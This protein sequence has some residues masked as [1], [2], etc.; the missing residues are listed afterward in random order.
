TAGSIYD[1]ACAAGSSVSKAVHSAEEGIMGGVHGAED[2]IDKKAHGLAGVVKDVPLLGS[3]AKLG[4]DAVGTYAQFEGGLLGGATT[5]LGGIVNA[6]AHPLDTAKGLMSL[7]EHVPGPIGMLIKAGKNA[8]DVVQGK[9]SLGDAL[10]NTFNP[11]KAI[12]DDAK[13]F[14]TL[15][16]AVL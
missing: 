1:G 7:S 11:I 2:W 16:G 5:M 4:A 13:F 14:K 8:S 12:E 3:V 6:V 15:G 10:N 9:E